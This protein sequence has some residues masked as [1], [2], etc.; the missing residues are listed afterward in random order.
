MT[1]GNGFQPPGP[2]PRLSV[3]TAVLDRAGSLE[4]CLESVARQRDVGIEHIVIDGGSS[5]GSV[6]IL[7]RWSDRLAH[8]SSGPDAGIASAMNKGLARATGDWVL[9]LHADDELLGNDAVARALEALR[10]HPGADIAGFPIRYGTHASARIV[11]PRG[12][13]PWMRF[14]TGFLHQGTLVRRSVFER[15]G[16]HDTALA[17]AMDYD[18]FLRAWLQGVPM[19]TLDSPVLTLM[20]DTGVSARRD[21]A[22]LAHRFGEERRIHAAHASGAWRYAYAAYW[23]IYPAY[24]RLFARDARRPW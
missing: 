24:R 1:P 14:K 5:D 19:V 21:P 23:R 22:G 16:A 7:E 2:P 17:V 11:R 6:A 3:V 15:V 9:F 20:A 4:R 8:W 12:A 10:A 13:T 18:F